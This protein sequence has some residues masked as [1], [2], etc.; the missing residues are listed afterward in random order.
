MAHDIGKEVYRSFRK[1]RDVFL[2][3]IAKF[4]NF[5]R[6]KPYMITLLGAVFMLFFVYYL[7]TDVIAAFFMLFFA[8]TCD[9]LD[10]SLARLQKL[11]SDKGKFIDR[12]V[13][14]LNF[15]IYIFGLSLA[16]LMNPLIGIIVVYLMALA[17]ILSIIKNY[18]SVKTNWI[19]RAEGGT[20][21]FFSSILAY[22]FFL[23]FF[24]TKI[25]LFDL[26]MIVVSIFLFVDAFF[27]F[28]WIIR[29]K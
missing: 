26:G 2:M 27:T 20:I 21:T 25:N 1:P 5:L 8:V 18:F 10:G 7:P 15:S 29:N 23:L 17:L 19:F 12:T 9:T 6:V 4:L 22:L 28:L 16:N 14:S 24:L 13:D 11:H 3:P